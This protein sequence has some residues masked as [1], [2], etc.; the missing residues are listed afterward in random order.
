MKRRS[1]EIINGGQKHKT[2]T[3]SKTAK[4]WPREN[5]LKMREM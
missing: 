5:D 1:M 3:E 2:K 4:V